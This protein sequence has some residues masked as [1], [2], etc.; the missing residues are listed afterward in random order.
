[1]TMKLTMVGSSGGI[2]L[3]V[4]NVNRAGPS[5]LVDVDGELLLFD[6][7]RS[8]HPNILRAGYAPS[9]IEHV[10]VTH[11]HSDHG[12][13][14]PDLVLSQWIASGKNHWNV[15]G[16]EGTLHLIDG[17]FGDDGAY[18]ADIVSRSEG[19]ARRGLIEPRIGKPLGRPGFNVTEIA[20]PGVV[21]SGSDW[22]VRASFAPKHSQPLLASIAYRVESSQ[23]S[24]VITG[25]T[26]PHEDVVEFARG[27]DVLVHDCTILAR[28][29]FY[30][31]R[32]THT[33]PKS[34][35]WVAAQAGVK[36]VI[37]THIALRY[38]HPE[39]L[40]SYPGLVAESFSGQFLVAEDLL[41]LDVA[42][43]DVL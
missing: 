13:G 38:D 37:G 23:G 18:R 16:P 14:L 12:V 25:D 8:A 30:T 4:S 33:D 20:E 29:G 9:S 2:A 21:C 1:M 28:T 40:A 7:G 19:P 24:V 11:L 43:G 35:G 22:E 6:V 3:D 41:Q 42:T 34:L 26:G 31:N 27:C 5:V 10:F 32:L 17:L 15:Y 36:T 39:T